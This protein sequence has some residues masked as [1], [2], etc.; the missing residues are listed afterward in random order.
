MAN[1][2]LFDNYVVPRNPQREN[3]I[4][5]AKSVVLLSLGV[6]F[7]YSIASGNLSNYIN[8]RFAWLSYVAA[9][10]FLLLGVANAVDLLLHRDY[11]LLD[12]SHAPITGKVIL[13]V[14]VPLALGLLV[15]SR[16]LGSAAAAG[17]R[18]SQCRLCDQC[19]HLHHGPL[20]ME[21]AGLAA[22][23]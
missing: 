23:L 16:P 6:Y 2:E 5:W 10:L 22:R 9:G 18:Q 7:I 8:Q 13:I 14:A 3:M 12:R 21:C 4:G 1:L 20:K 11:A 17:Q 15:P 19:H